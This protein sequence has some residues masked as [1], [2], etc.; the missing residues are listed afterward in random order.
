MH[1]FLLETNLG[2]A[3]PWSML[4]PHILPA[5]VTIL[6]LHS[7][8]GAWIITGGMHA[9]VMKHVGKAV[10][11]YVTAQGMKANINVIGIAPWGC[12]NNKETLIDPD[13]SLDIRLN[14]E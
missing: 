1:N 2:L 8:V 7:C 6:S 10:Q 4:L 14:I 11:D 12:V 3:R 5:E 9:G 13:V